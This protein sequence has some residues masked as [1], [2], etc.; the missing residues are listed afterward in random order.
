MKKA[1][2]RTIETL[3]NSGGDPWEY[4]SHDIGKL[5]SWIEKEQKKAKPLP[6]DSDVKCNIC[7]DKGEYLDRHT[8]RYG[9]VKCECKN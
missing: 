9:I 8:E 6:V 7:D 2:K 1:L 5:V 3:I 4:N